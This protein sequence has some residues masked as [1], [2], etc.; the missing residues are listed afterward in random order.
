MANV[1]YRS[2]K[3]DHIKEV[4]LTHN[5]STFMPPKNFNFK[6]EKI[7]SCFKIHRY[8]DDKCDVSCPEFHSQKNSKNELFSCFE[9]NLY[10]DKNDKII[11]DKWLNSCIMAENETIAFFKNLMNNGIIIINQKNDLIKEKSKLSTKKYSI[12]KTIPKMKNGEAKNN[13]LT[14]LKTFDE[15]I[16]EINNKINEKNKLYFEAIKNEKIWWLDYHINVTTQNINDKKVKDTKIDKTK[17]ELEHS[18]ELRK[19]LADVDY[20]KKRDKEICR[21]KSVIIYFNEMIEDVPHK[22]P[23][24]KFPISNMGRRILLEGISKARSMINSLNEEIYPKIRF[25]YVRDH[26]YDSLHKIMDFSTVE[27]IEKKGK[28]KITKKFNIK[29]HI[30][31]EAVKQVCTSVK[32]MVTNYRN[33]NIARFTLTKRKFNKISKNMCI[34]KGYFAVGSIF[35]TIFKSLKCKKDGKPYNIFNVHAQST[36]SNLVYNDNTKEYKLYVPKKVEVNQ[37]KN[38]KSISCDFGL[39]TFITGLSENEVV[40]VGR[41]TDMKITQYIKQLRILKTKDGKVRKRKKKMETIRRKIKYAADEL[42]WKTINFMVNNYKTVIVGN[43]SPKSIVRKDGNMN[44][45]QKDLTHAL[46]FYKFKMR[47]EDKCKKN[48]MK[49]YCTDE[50]GTSKGCSNCGEYNNVGGSKKYKCKGCGL[51]MDRDINSSRIIKM[52][53]IK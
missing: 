51:E 19:K 22:K 49:Y 9:I 53:T 36:T 1:I 52:L 15:K 47:L 32:S 3:F 6:E 21:L 25:E 11:V 38:I 29:K 27:R 17:A 41:A 39:R 50:Y 4:V 48:G 13:L 40:E 5:K 30:L 28:K 10:F 35:T 8:I 16:L 23:E 37:T 20:F 14:E 44:K 12:E 26:L 33:G 34:E 24:S 31:D 2:K 43:M 46:S 42:H 45:E 18:I 7:K